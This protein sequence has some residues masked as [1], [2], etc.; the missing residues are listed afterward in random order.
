MG[1]VTSQCGEDRNTS[2]FHIFSLP[3][4]KITHLYQIK[5]RVQIARRVYV[6]EVDQQLPIIEQY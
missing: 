6:A 4:I 2:G 1:E 5:P 3:H